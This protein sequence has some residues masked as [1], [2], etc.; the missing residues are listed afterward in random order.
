MILTNSWLFLWCIGI[1]KL[2]GNLGEEKLVVTTE[3]Q[4]EFQNQWEDE[5]WS[6]TS[7]KRKF[8]AIMESSATFVT[9]KHY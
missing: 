8:T 1:Q 2:F 3:S 9:F 7:I 4:Q 5:F 6:T